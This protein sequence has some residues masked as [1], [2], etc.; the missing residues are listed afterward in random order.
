MRAD[1]GTSLGTPGLRPAV[2]AGI[3]ACL[4]ALADAQPTY[5]RDVAP[6]MQ[7]KCQGCHRPDDIAPFPLLTYDDASSQASSI[8]SGRRFSIG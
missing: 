4:P 7:Q 6:I 8:R 2:L 3:L 5:T 1:S